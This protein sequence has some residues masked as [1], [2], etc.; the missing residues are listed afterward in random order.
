MVRAIPLLVC[1]VL[2]LAACDRFSSSTAQ[3]SVT[4]TLVHSSQSE[5]EFEL[6]NTASRAIQFDGNLEGDRARPLAHAAECQPEGSVGWAK[7]R[8]IIGS[9]A[10]VEAITVRPGETLRL[11]VH[12]DFVGK[13]K[14]G[15]CRMELQLADGLVLP[16][17]AFKP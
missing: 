2:L 10:K 13:F 16:S 6:K 9:W 11:L 8:P 7:S 15:V 1:A 12:S 14:N 17:N 5:L 3:G 4:L